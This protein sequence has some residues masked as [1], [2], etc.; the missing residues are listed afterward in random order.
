MESVKLQKYVAECG[1]MSRRAAEK[2][3]EAGNFAVNGITASLGMRI[4][5]ENDAVTYKGKSLTPPSQR[6]VYIMLNKPKGVVTTMNDEKGRKSVADIVDI[7]IRVYPVGRLDLNSEGLLLMTNDGELANAIAHPSGEIKK[8]YAVT[9][10]G[11]VEN[12]ELDRLRAVK[13]L[14]GEKITP[15]GVE[16]VSRNEQSSV[17]KFTLSEGK[18]REIRRI[19]ETVG[20]YITKLK[21][22]SLGPLRIGD[23]KPGEYRELT[24]SELKALKAAVSKNT[25]R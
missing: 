18:N 9:L 8:V 23:M 13:M 4:D 22:I 11:K 14:D 10:K 1:L 21:R 3:I 6:K 17:V 24:A 15:V 20:V 16:L 2:E 19:C 25:K 7:G 12:E 5:P